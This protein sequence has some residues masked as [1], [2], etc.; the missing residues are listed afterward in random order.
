MANIKINDI[1]PAGVEFFAD[2][3]NFMSE[4]NENDIN[5]IIGGKTDIITKSCNVYNTH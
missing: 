2:S 1:K 3:E 5:Y 4:L